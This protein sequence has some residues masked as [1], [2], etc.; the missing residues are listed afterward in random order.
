MYKVDEVPKSVPPSKETPNISKRGS[1][2]I[3]KLQKQGSLLLNFDFM[4]Q[5][6]TN[7]MG[8]A[9]EA[10]LLPFLMGDSKK[11]TT[12]TKN[13]DDD[14]KKE[15]YETMCV[16]SKYN[17]VSMF[18]QLCLIIY[19]RKHLTT[20]P[21]ENMNEFF[22]KVY[23]KPFPFPGEAIRVAHPIP[24]SNAISLF[25]GTHLLIRPADDV[26]PQAPDAIKTLCR[27]FNSSQMMHIFSCML[28][29]K[30]MVFM[31]SSISKVSECIRGFVALLY[32]FQWQHILIPVLPTRLLDYLFAPMPFIMG[33]HSD[34]HEAVTRASSDQEIVLVNVDTSTISPELNFQMPK[35]AKLYNNIQAGFILSP[36]GEIIHPEYVQEAFLLYFVRIFGDYRRF[37]VSK[38]TTK[39]SRF[40]FDESR[41]I[42]Q[43]GVFENLL[44][45]LL[46][47]QLYEQWK[48]DRIHL[49]EEY[50]L[51]IPPGRFELE[52]SKR[53]PECYNINVPLST[54]SS[55]FTSQ[56]VSRKRMVASASSKR[57]RGSRLKSFIFGI[58]RR[59]TQQNP[60]S[61]PSS[62]KMVRLPSR[63][64]LQKAFEEHLPADDY[65]VYNSTSS[66]S[67]VHGRDRKGSFFDAKISQINRIK[68]SMNAEESSGP[69]FNPSFEL[70]HRHAKPLLLNTE[71]LFADF[72]DDFGDDI[73]ANSDADDDD[74]V[75]SSSD[76]SSDAVVVDNLDV[77]SSSSILL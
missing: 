76:V 12:P 30:R 17:W 19:I 32:P 66:S 50:H 41:F 58:N 2:N 45:R 47:S 24:T 43:H 62:K 26:M 75:D 65:H 74:V 40:V 59:L 22:E 5:D 25:D 42:D 31:G 27:I 63:K 56:N 4:N 23:N 38:D 49:Y 3:S 72:D 61:S 68:S 7:D 21:I 6:A 10:I 54:A 13:D 11:A 1:V 77:P 52:C 60:R 51:K 14:K 57:S 33:V 29:E 69:K 15:R 9:A 28:F 35:K 55:S 34:H 37:I 20:D 44:Y 36:N 70:F 46:E 18:R 73:L 71:S 53:A 8:Q 64:D 67:L 16:L 48:V 39:G